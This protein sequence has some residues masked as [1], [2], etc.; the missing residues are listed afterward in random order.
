MARWETEAKQIPEHKAMEVSHILELA[1]TKGEGWPLGTQRKLNKGERILL[2][3][4]RDVLTRRPSKLALE[5][6]EEI[7]SENRKLKSA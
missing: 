7:A 3:L 4:S 5:K 6:A 1:A 2:Q